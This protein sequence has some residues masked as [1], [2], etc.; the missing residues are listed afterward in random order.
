MLC[1]VCDCRSL[2]LQQNT[3]LGAIPSL[4]TSLQTGLQFNC[5]PK[6]FSV[7]YNAACNL[8]G[9]ERSALTAL[10]TNDGGSAWTLVPSWPSSLSGDPCFDGWTGVSCQIGAPSHV[11]YD[12]TVLADLEQDLP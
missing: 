6:S 7:N 5:Y 2:N 3:L 11:T 4:S 12:T 1:S 10:Y 8:A 9:S